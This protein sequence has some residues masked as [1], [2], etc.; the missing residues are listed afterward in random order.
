MT[1][2]TVREVMTTV[3]AAVSADTAF[4]DV[5][6][7]MNARG[8]SALPV[9]DGDGRVAGIVSQTDLLRKSEYEEEPDARRPPLSHHHRVQSEGL[10]AR[11]VMSAPAV[12][13]GPDAWSV[14]S[15][16]A[17]CSRCTCAR[18]RRSGTRSSPM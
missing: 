16:L 5:I 2:R 1:H 14:S 3:V 11:D 17:T 15:A 10:T 13:I 7:M 12:T 18:M 4:K 9:L 8:V 6:T